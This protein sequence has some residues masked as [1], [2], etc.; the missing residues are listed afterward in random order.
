[1]LKSPS[2]WLNTP[3]LIVHHQPIGIHRAFSSNDSIPSIPSI[4]SVPS[5]PHAR[6]VDLPRP[7]EAGRR[8]LHRKKGI[9][10]YQTM[11]YHISIYY[12]NYIYIHIHYTHWISIII[13]ILWINNSYTTIYHYISWENS[14]L[15]GCFQFRTGPKSLAVG[16][17]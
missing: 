2:W 7:S 17:L 6:G 13:V 16:V 15:R 10:T 14:D 9:K 12:N 1:M 4:P 3:L 5:V 8:V 11:T